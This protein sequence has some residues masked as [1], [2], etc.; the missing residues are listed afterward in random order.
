VC[1]ERDDPCW[2]AFG[3]TSGVLSETEIGRPILIN[4]SLTV[5]PGGERF[6]TKDVAKIGEVFD[7]VLKLLGIVSI[8]WRGR[9]PV[10]H[11]GV[12][13]DTD[14]EFDAIPSSPMSFNAD[15]IPGAAVVGAESSAVHRDVHVLP[16]EESGDSIH[17][18]AYVGDGESFHPALNHA[19]PRRVKA[20]LFDGF[21]VFEVC[22]DTIVGLVESY[23]EETSYGDGMW[24]VS[25]SSFFVGFPGWRHA[26]NCF[27]HRLGEIGG[28]VTVYMVCNCWVYP[29]LSA[30]HLLKK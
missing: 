27:N 26:A 21:A 20:V 24:V 1:S 22:F 12:D 19:V 6:V 28:E 9:E 30:S 5:T 3:V 17:H 25:F 15:V 7:Q 8:P 11:T 16:P 29:F 10:D 2:L 14:V 23:F 4:D 13:I 18:L